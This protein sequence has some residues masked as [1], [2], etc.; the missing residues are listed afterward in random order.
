M[1]EIWTPEQEKELEA[2]RELAELEM[3]QAYEICE[4]CEDKFIIAKT[5]HSV[6][7]KGKNVDVPKQF[8]AAAG[9]PQADKTIWTPEF[10]E[11]AIRISQAG[12]QRKMDYVKKDFWIRFR[13]DIETFK[14]FGCSGSAALLLGIS[15]LCWNW[16][17]KDTGESVAVL[18]D[19]K[20]PSTLMDEPTLANQPLQ[21]TRYAG[22]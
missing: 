1:N 10:T 13:D 15:L 21:Q 22:S 16:L 19:S 12:I 9:S 14:P 11:E 8:R 3:M 7:R 18:S 4:Q 2:I 17:D 5:Y 20:S 6:Y